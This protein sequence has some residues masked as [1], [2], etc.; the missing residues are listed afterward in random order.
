M[1]GLSLVVLGYVSV[2][3][4]RESAAPSAVGISSEGAEIVAVLN[5]VVVG[6]TVA[7]FLV[8]AVDLDLDHVLEDIIGR[9]VR[10]NAAHVKDD[11][12]VAG[13]LECPSSGAVH[14][15]LGLGGGAAEFVLA[16]LA[17]V[18]CEVIR[19][20]HAQVTLPHAVD[21]LDFCCKCAFLNVIV[22]VRVHTEVDAVYLDLQFELC[23]VLH[24]RCVRFNRGIGD[25]DVS[26][27]VDGSGFRVLMA[28]PVPVV[29]IVQLISGF[30]IRGNIGVEVFDQISSVQSCASVY[31]LGIVLI[32][33]DDRIDND[34]FVIGDH[35]Y[36][37]G[38]AVDGD[39]IAKRV[40]GITS[41]IL[42]PAA[43]IVPS[44]EHKTIG[45]AVIVVYIEL[46]QVH[47]FALGILTDSSG[48]VLLVRISVAVNDNIDRISLGRRKVLVLGL[49]RD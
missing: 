7:D 32:S 44:F 21:E 47:G 13:V 41:L 19:S 26:P 49:K 40:V 33:V 18:L 11:A 37:V 9:R 38:P 43:V 27:A 22:P 24:S 8:D 15:G 45:R 48:G 2:R 3:L 20:L 4:D 28:V 12:V 34:L 30:L 23:K 42:V 10:F 31:R 14:K 6:V 29:P 25:I 16:K 1:S 17:N 36:N 46:A 5:E 35:A 39:G